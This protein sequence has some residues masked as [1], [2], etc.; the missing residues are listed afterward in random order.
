MILPELESVV[1]A[2]VAPV[3][4]VEIPEEPVLRVE[5]DDDPFDLDLDA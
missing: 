4:P 5:R 2:A 3:Q 1:A